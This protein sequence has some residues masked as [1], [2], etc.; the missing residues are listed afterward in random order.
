M[1]AGI[2]AGSVTGPINGL[3]ITLIGLPPFI[4]T[5]GT[6]SIARSGLRPDQGLSGDDPR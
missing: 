6:L 1:I 3:L 5:L 4:A 2:L